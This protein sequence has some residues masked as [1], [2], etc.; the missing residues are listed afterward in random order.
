MTVLRGYSTLEQAHLARSL[1]ESEGIA[2]EVLDEGTAVS[3]PYL[4]MST[5]IR[6]AVADEDAG[7]ARE[8]LEL[9]PEAPT[10]G[11]SGRGGGLWIGIVLVVA[12]GS[13][14][15]LGI[16]Q[17]ASGIQAIPGEVIEM[18]RN[19]DGRVDHRTEYDPRGRP[20]R[21]FEDD[22]FDGR[23]SS[24]YEFGA[25]MVTRSEHD[26]DFNGVF[27]SVVEYRY[28][29]PHIETV[30]PGGTGHPLFRHEF[31]HGRLAVT[32]SDPDRDGAWDERIVYDAMGREERQTLR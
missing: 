18:D 32:W 10:P 23:W 21:T 1:L 2:A 13:I 20:L 4:L 12:I 17:R 7:R 11:H 9:P 8:I 26:L 30:R 24:R 25:G 15:V 14:L 27:D 31:R 3:A 6:L 19:G 22:N 29:L 28:G 16:R 5:G